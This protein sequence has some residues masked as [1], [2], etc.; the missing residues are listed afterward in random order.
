[1]AANQQLEQ[2]AFAPVGAKVAA[3]RTDD[4]C[5]GTGVAAAHIGTY[6]PR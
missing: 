6:V 2:V 3:V 5:P 1:M 4:T